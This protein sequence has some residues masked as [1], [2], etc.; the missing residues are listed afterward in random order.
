MTL[1]VSLLF[2]ASQI[3]RSIIWC[4]GSSL[5]KIEVLAKISTCRNIGPRFFAS[6]RTYG[7]LLFSNTSGSLWCPENS[8][9]KSLNIAISKYRLFF[10]NTP[11]PDSIQNGRYREHALLCLKA[12]Y[13]KFQWRRSNVR[14]NLWPSLLDIEISQI[15]H[16]QISVFLAAFKAAFDLLM[17]SLLSLTSQNELLMALWLSLR[18]VRSVRLDS[19]A[20]KL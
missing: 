19:S 13:S 17:P 10:S 15:R 7:G 9:S 6:K 18:S 20:H 4:L 14:K 5:F 8:W 2:L 12:S 16:L 11:A 3:L 1:R